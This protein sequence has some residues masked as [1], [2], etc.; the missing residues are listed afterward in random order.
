MK[1]KRLLI[2]VLIFYCFLLINANNDNENEI[3]SKVKT[4]SEFNSNEEKSEENLRKSVK[5]QLKIEDFDETDGEDILAEDLETNEEEIE[6]E[7]PEEP[8]V[9]RELTERERLAISLYESA[10][11]LLNSSRSDRSKAY[12]LMTE[13]AKLDYEPAMES[14][15][16]Q[17]LFGDE[18]P[19]DLNVAKQY[20]TRLSLKGNPN[21]QLVCY[22]FCY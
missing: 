15:A 5:K 9:V 14:V 7:L 17:H 21:S 16:K 19:I 20:F 18:L 3:K 2:F 8:V 13:S 4:K 10:Q 12:Q 11:S 22:H 6:E 1:T